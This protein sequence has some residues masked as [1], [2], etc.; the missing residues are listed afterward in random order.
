M[1]CVILVDFL[2]FLNSVVFSYCLGISS[3]FQ[4]LKCYM[5]FF[6]IISYLPIVCKDCVPV[7][8]ESVFWWH[9][10]LLSEHTYPVSDQCLTQWL[11]PLLMEAERAR[12]QTGVW[13]GL[14]CANPLIQNDL[15]YISLFVTCI[16]KF[17]ISESVCVWVCTR[18]VKY[19]YTLAHR[20]LFHYYIVA[21]INVMGVFSG[22]F[23][24]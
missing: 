4:G 16:Y 7:R 18:P 23:W 12:W 3:L 10:S 6:F 22:L 1:S 15:L 11:C 19:L 17:L 20:K 21:C 2:F 14:Y 13:N 9:S 5:A 24:G 8:G